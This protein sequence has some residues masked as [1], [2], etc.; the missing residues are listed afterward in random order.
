M[1]TRAIT[2]IALSMLVLFAFQ[3]FFVGNQPVNTVNATNA[4]NTTVVQDKVAM[5]GTQGGSGFI[6]KTTDTQHAALPP[7]KATV[8]LQAGENS[9]DIT[10]ETDLYYAVIS[11]HGGAFKTFKLKKYKDSLKPGSEYVDLIKVSPPSLPGVISITGQNGPLDMSNALFKADREKI[12]LQ[13]ADTNDS[14]TLN[15]TASFKDGTSI[16][17]SL[18]IKNG[19]YWMDFSVQMNGA[20]PSN[21]SFFL[22]DKPFNDVS[23]YIFSGP[24]Y[25]SKGSLEQVTLKDPGEMKSFTGPVDWMSYGDNYF[26]NAVIPG[27]SMDAWQLDFKK[28]DASGLTESK[29]TTFSPIKDGNIFKVGLYFGPKEIDRLNSLGHHLSGVINFGWFDIIAKPVLYLLKFIY[30][31]IGNYGIAIILVTVFIKLLFWPLAQKSA[32]SMKTMQKLQPKMKKLK[33]KYGDDKEKLNKEMMQLYRTYN[34]NPMSGCMPML[35]Q[36]PVFFALYKVLLQSIELR[37]APFMLWI[38]DLSAPDRL[39]IPGVDIPYLGGIPVLTLL[40]GISMYLQQKLSPS[41]LD[42]SQA[43]MMQ[44]LPVIFTFMFI[45]FP[46]GLVLYW[47]VNNILSI[48]QQYYVN[49]YTD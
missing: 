11:E 17:K 46:S 31:Y 12:D 24:S 25:M 47:F 37:H 8:F 21:A 16:T 23:R 1:E 7:V 10:L 32:K 20:S 22:Y 43:K 3:Y 19:T 49:K 13:G 33:D 40:M 26:M 36:I 38:N 35:I 9:R 14:E 42:P 5:P 30:T 39:M 48:A 6:K 15:L 27:T 29:L 2:A 44:F 41:S 28:L 45:S 34:V 4:T 18:T